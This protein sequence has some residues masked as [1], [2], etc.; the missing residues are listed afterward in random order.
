MGDTLQLAEATSEVFVIFVFPFQK[1]LVLVTLY[2]G[3]Y[4]N[5]RGSKYKQKKPT[6]LRD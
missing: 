5:S 3:P 4:Y 2:L 1:S 6:I